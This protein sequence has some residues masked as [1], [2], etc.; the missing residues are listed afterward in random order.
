MAFF[1]FI[2]VKYEQLNVQ[3][4][5]YVRNMYSKSNEFF[6]SASPYGQILNV[7]KEFYQFTILYQKNIVRNLDIE[8][9]TNLKILRTYSRIAG[10]NPSRATSA[11]GTLRISTKS[12]I[13]LTNMIL[14]G[15]ITLSDKSLLKN[16]TNGLDYT[17]RLGSEQETFRLLNNN[18]FYVN[19]IQG[20]YEEQ[21]FT[22][23][24]YKNQSYSVNVSNLSEIDNF[25]VQ[26][27]YNNSVLTLK[28]SLYDMLRNER[29]CYSRTGITG[30]LDIYFGN[31]YCGF[32]PDTGSIIT[33]RYL[34]T[35][36]NSGNIL[37]PLVND[38][39]FITEVN[40]S[41]GNY[42]NI[43]QLFDITITE[44]IQFASNG[45][46]V[47]ETRNALSNVSRNFVLSTPQQYIYHL[48]RLNLFSKINVYN[49]LSDNNYTN[50]NKVY[51]FLIPKVSD[52]FSQTVNYF[53]LPISIYSLDSYEIDKTITYLQRLGNIPNGTELEV[54]QP[55]ISKSV[56][57]IYVIKNDGFSDESIS[58]DITT[59]VSNYLAY[60]QRD[61]RIVRS[62]LIST[63]E[64]VLG[65]DSINLTFL[66][67]KNEIYHITK[68]DSNDI[69][70]L[71]PIMGD[72]ILEKDELG[73]IR[74][75][76]ADRNGTYYNE[77]TMSGSLGPINIIF[78]GITKK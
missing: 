57:F 3:I 30:G 29:A 1:D 59:A 23:T 7:L 18:A 15:S 76:W 28:D 49:T 63:I 13:D 72:I 70:G 39:K 58:S 14:G 20:R 27:L 21:N 65:V 68:P 44:A 73:L 46:G 77:N 37:T 51:L 45:E 71:D 2:D 62:D 64:G 75:G 25:D 16:S 19:I 35:N 38:F 48:T 52:Y 74:G 4:N 10:H 26:V 66:S 11:S 47:L 69:M 43:N 12:N 6:S 78:V 34:L 5:T 31:G 36:G 32:I 61:D 9:S 56:M 41:A 40:D 8:T 24:G 55:R 67:E 33:V 60:S 17:I 53:N 54:I 22:G 42:I 50:D